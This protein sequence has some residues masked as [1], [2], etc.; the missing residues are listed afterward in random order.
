MRLAVCICVCVC[1]CVSVCV[2]RL[3]KGLFDNNEACLIHAGD[4]TSVCLLFPT[5]LISPT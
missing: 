1:V 5:A 3:C 4:Y 2:G